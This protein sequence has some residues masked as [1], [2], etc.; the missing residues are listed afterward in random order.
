[1]SIVVIGAGVELSA[2]V[3]NDF[4]NGGVTWTL[5]CTPPAI[6]CGTLSPSTS[7]TTVTYAPSGSTPAQAT[8]K[9]TLNADGTTSDSHTFNIV[10]TV[11]NSC[12]SA[13]GQESLLKG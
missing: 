10:S 1:A 13:G 3:Q 5:T 7:T 6:S 11:T 9:A 8:V 2:Y 12:G 4:T